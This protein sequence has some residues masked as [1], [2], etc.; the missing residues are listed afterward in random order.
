MDEQKNTH[1][2]KPLTENWITIFGF[3]LAIVF[4]AGEAILIT[5]DIFQ[6]STHPYI[7]ILIYIVGPSIL[8][9]GLLLVPLGMWREHRKRIQNIPSKALPAFDLNNPRHRRNL[10]I[11]FVVTTV[12]FILSMVGTYN[13]YHLTE[14]N[15]FC[16]VTCHQVMK[17]EHTA[18]QHSPHARVDCVE[19][20]IG[21]GAD[22][23]VKSKLSGAWQ[24]V[25]VLTNTYELPL[26]TPIENLR[27]ARETCEQCH[28]PE[29]FFETVQ[30]SLVFYGN[31]EENTPYKLDMLLHVGHSNNEQSEEN[32][33][34]HWHIGL[35]HK[36]EYYATDKKRQNIPWIRVTYDDGTVEEFYNEEGEDFDP[37]SVPPKEIR[38]MDCI[39]CHNRPS[40]RFHSPLS[41][42]N[43][44]M[45]QGKISPKIPDIKLNTVEILQEEYESTEE[46]LAQIE[47][48]LRDEYTAWAEEDSS[49]QQMLEQAIE[50]TKTAFQRNIFPEQKVE[51]SNYPW[52]VGHFNFPGCYR[53]HDDMHES[54]EGKIVS[55]DCN[56]CHTFVKQGEGW[57]EIVDLEYEEQDFLHPRGM[58][59]AWEGMNCHECHGPGMM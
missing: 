19:C 56:L 54:P 49:N 22:W 21:A 29:K 13:A 39:D 6:G 42:V 14:S 41:I 9:L 34:I 38:T 40:H 32:R 28:W 17:P 55:N 48:T 45:Q 27:P 4:L 58:G 15:Q 10:A 24:V 1:Y 51:W 23:F 26:E 35:D 59:D 16:G 7:G 57:D 20:H 53:C 50:T 37:S 30:K 12:F 47:E 44:A 25:A 52:N 31:D 46:A 18:F 43:E 36:L 33:G 8:I 2:Q 5:I 11:F 3:M